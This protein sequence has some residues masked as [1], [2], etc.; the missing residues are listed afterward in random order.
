MRAVYAIHGCCADETDEIERIEIELPAG[1]C[2]PSH[3]D[4]ETEALSITGYDGH[5]RCD[6]C[7][8]RIRYRAHYVG[9]PVPPIAGA[10]VSIKGEQS[11]SPDCNA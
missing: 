4:A 1:C 7:G 8:H 5:G 3:P 11:E 2:D 10:I 6:Y 9:Y